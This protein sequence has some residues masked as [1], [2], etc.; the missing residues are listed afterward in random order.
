M[1]I[2]YCKVLD[3][4]E[5]ALPDQCDKLT[6][7]EPVD[8]GD[9]GEMV[10]NQLVPSQSI[11]GQVD[12]E[13]TNQDFIAKVYLCT[14]VEV[15]D[16]KSFWVTGFSPAM[17]KTSDK[18]STLSSKKLDCQHYPDKLECGAPP[19]GGHRA[20]HGSGRLRHSDGN[21]SKPLELRSQWRTSS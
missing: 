16:E 8:W 10:P 9:W 12:W 21:P 18:L 14:G 2:K 15:G 5:D 3:K 6:G 17:V 4:L 1:K 11:G 7:S 19:G 13:G 20:P